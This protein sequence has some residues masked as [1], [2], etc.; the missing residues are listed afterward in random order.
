MKKF[1]AAS[2]AAAMVLSMGATAFAADEVAN[3]VTGL[4]TDAIYTESDGK[5]AKTLDVT[6]G[7]R[8]GYGKTAYYALEA[9]NGN[10][11]VT[12]MEA[13]KGMSIKQK[14]EMNGTAVE[15]LQIVKKKQ[16]V[17]GGQNDY[18]YFLAITMKPS[19]SM[20]QIDVIG[21]ITLKK[22][23]DNKIDETYDIEIPVGYAY[24]GDRTIT[25]SVKIFNFGTTGESPLEG[26]EDDTLD[27]D[28]VGY[29]EVDT[30]G[31][32]KILLGCDV[33]FNS[34]VAAKFPEAN[35]D[36]VNG[37]GANFNKT[38]LLTIEADPDTYLYQ[39]VDGVLKAVK[40]EYDEY[41]EAFKVKTRTLGEYVISDTELNLDGQSEGSSD[42]E[43]GTEVVNP[44]S[45]A[46]A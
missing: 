39:N 13:V 42:K 41:E 17:N 24:A 14:W 10:V 25:D 31:Q 35:L 38:G 37:N 16:S 2:L 20:S 11:W 33:D 15:K 8:L 6:G 34:D 19:T 23:G 32:G 1:M 7:A 29:F 22:S 27:I 4:A 46:R 45:G 12:E 28:G 5:V 3:P 43:D 9:N 30:N 40:A 21:E 36:F 44:P 18:V 26:T